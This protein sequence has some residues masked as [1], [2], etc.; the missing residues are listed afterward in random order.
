MNLNQKISVVKG[1]QEPA[2]ATFSIALDADGVTVCYE[3]KASSPVCYA[4]SSEVRKEFW[5]DKIPQTHEDGIV[6]KNDKT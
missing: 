1:C 3:W 4:D 2:V 6:V 5:C